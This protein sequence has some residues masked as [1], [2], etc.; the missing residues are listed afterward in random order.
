MLVELTDQK[1]VVFIKSR[2]QMAPFTQNTI[3]ALTKKIGES[4]PTELFN[5]ESWFAA[6]LNQQKTAKNQQIPF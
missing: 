1:N 5:T 3:C 4:D 2:N 6:R